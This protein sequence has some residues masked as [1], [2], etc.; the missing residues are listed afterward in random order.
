MLNVTE[1][2][3][4]HCRY[5]AWGTE[6]PGPHSGHFLTLYLPIWEPGP[7]SRG[8]DR[9]MTGKEG[10]AYLAKHNSGIPESPGHTA[11]YYH[12]I[13]VWSLIMRSLVPWR[14]GFSALDPAS[15]DLKFHHWPD[16]SLLQVL[17]RRGLR[18]FATTLFPL[19][20]HLLGL[21]CGHS[22]FTM[23]YQERIKPT[24]SRR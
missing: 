17:Q 7:G 2:G 3:A 16:W 21:V 23:G 5:R 8:G 6:R 10:E 18:Y 9:V 1:W 24:P 14:S 4:C 19:S 20:C 11:I 22:V 12:S 13:P 15:W